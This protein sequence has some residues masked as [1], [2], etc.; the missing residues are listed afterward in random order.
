MRNL[1]LKVSAGDEAFTDIVE[2]A[3]RLGEFR[4]MS[5]VDTYFAV[6]TGR[7]KLREISD[8]DVRRGRP[9]GRGADSQP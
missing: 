4:S 2:R 1:E 8:G 5:Q 9:D 7:L 3:R 6:P